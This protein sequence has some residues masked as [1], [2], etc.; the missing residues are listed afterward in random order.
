MDRAKQNRQRTVPRGK[1]AYLWRGIRFYYRCFLLHFILSLSAVTVLY[2]SVSGMQSLFGG[3]AGLLFLRRA[4]CDPTPPRAHTVREISVAVLSTAFRFDTTPD[5]Y[6]TQDGDGVPDGD[7]EPSDRY[8]RIWDEAEQTAPDLPLDAAEI[9]G[10]RAGDLYNYTHD[11]PAGKTAVLPTD[12]S[13]FGRY[14]AENG[15]ILYAN[16]TPY[17]PDTD[18]LLQ[19]AYPIA[20]ASVQTGAGDS[21]SPPLVLILHTHGTEAYAPDGALSVGDETTFR[22]DDIT[23]NVVS[24][25]AVLARVLSE[26]NIPTLH[27]ET[28]F[29]LASYDGAYNKAA[30]YIRETVKTYPSIRYVFDVHR[31][32]LYSSDGDILRPVTEIGG[33]VTAQMMCVVGTDA[34]GA[35]HAGWRDNLSVAVHLQK[36]LLDRY[37]RFVRPINLRQATFNGQYAPGSLLLEI[38]SAG[39]SIEEA[40]SAAYH[41]GCVLAEMILA[42]G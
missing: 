2:L 11:V 40:R 36:R 25:G 9:L 10:E 7:K 38:G 35:D 6:F 15:G 20:P 26:Y 30:A 37:D 12:L 31:D 22:S 34:A 33:E 41:L 8:E 19:E 14:T 23:E 13:G 3:Q 29:D 4:L 27:C 42:G 32:A 18:A 5:A 24:V 28:M 16:Q 21:Q 1:I 39:N 17:V